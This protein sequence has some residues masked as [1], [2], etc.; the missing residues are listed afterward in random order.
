MRHAPPD[1]GLWTGPKVAVYVR[2]LWGVIVA[3][4]TGWRWLRAPGFSLQVPRPRHPGPPRPPTGGRGKDALVER[5]GRLRREHPDKVVEVWAEDEARLGLKPGRSGGGGRSHE[6][7][8]ALRLRLR[9][10]GQRPE[11]GVGPAGGGYGLDGGRPGR[12]RPVGRPG[13]REAPG[14]ARGRR[15]LA[16]GQAAGLVLHRLPPCT[17]EL[18]P[19][20]RSGR[21]SA[22][23]PPTRGFDRAGKDP[24]DVRRAVDAIRPPPRSD[25]RPPCVAP[26]R[27]AVGAAKPSRRSPAS[28]FPNTP[29]KRI[30]RSG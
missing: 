8:V 14:P 12:V 2:D 11:P 18:Q 22:R 1:G 15:G 9:P 6:V 3:E 21:C 24:V 23:R 27:S 19:S 5:V 29:E 17:P 20:S 7:P 16:R 13:R 28:R 10:P 26:R 30:V 4:S 25:G